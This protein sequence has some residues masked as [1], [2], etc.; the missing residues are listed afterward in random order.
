MRQPP[1]LSTAFH[2]PV[3]TGTALIAIAVTLAWW[4]K[5]DI[6]PLFASAM[7]RRGELWRLITCMFPHAGI[8][9]LAFN[10]YW[11]W[12]FGTL[13]EE[14]FGHLKTAGFILLFAFGPSAW[15]FALGLGGVG[16]SGV[17]Y[18]LFGLLWMLSRQDE[19]F[20][21]AI[22]ARTVQL[23]IGWFLLCIVTTVTR[24]MPVGN[25]AHA[26]GAVLRILAGLAFAKPNTRAPLTAGISAIVLAGLWGST[27]GRP[28]I[29]LSGQAGF[30]EGQ[31]G[32]QEL[33]ANKNEEAIR[34]F[35]DA[36]RYQPR[37]SAYWYDLSLAYLRS[38][39][40][41]EALAAFRKSAELG[42]P[43]AQY[44]LWELYEHG[45]EPVPVDHVQALYWLKKAADQKYPDALN[46][47]A[48]TYATSSDPSVRNTAAA[49]DLAR[50]AVELGKDHPNP[51]H[52][53]TLA[54]ALYVNGQYRDAV[55]T[56]QKA[57]AL[58]TDEKKNGFEKQLKQYQEALSRNQRQGSR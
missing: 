15:E 5:I 26:I 25:V 50:Q 41:T 20:R 28:R 12:V 8:L 39:N 3:V 6:S 57:I 17:G 13:L 47:L 23:F 48:W 54:E 7:I 36:V 40:K 49:L 34:W 52:L 32:Y 1:K 27:L 37:G 44:Y 14:E 55:E 10:I 43:E 46:D 56:E 21:E 24:I 53:D 29:N 35:R 11:L 45:P 19:R 30:E 4:A 16:L 38:E 51:S 33:A 42:Q 58:A 18:G 9:H 22:D 2:Y 31:W